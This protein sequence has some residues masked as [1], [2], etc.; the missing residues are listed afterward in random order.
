MLPLYFF[1]IHF[2]FILLSTLG[3]PTCSLPCVQQHKL[4]YKLLRRDVENPKKE[5][6]KNGSYH[7][8]VAVA[9]DDDK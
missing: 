5:Q 6:D 7:F 3:F 2:N 9:D 4:H 8:V 1:N